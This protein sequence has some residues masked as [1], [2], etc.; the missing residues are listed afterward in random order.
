VTNK[1]ESRA[2]TLAWHGAKAHVLVSAQQWSL[3]SFLNLTGVKSSYNV[4][5]VSPVQQSESV[6]HR[7]ASPLCHHVTLSG[8]PVLCSRFSL[9]TCFFLVVYICESQSPDS[10]LL[11]FLPLVPIRLFFMSVSLFLLFTYIHLYHFSRFHIYALI[12][13][14]CFFLFLTYFAVYGSL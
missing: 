10:F 1:L 12:Y 2:L 9:V 11:P 5:L 3:F 7:C 13:D 4:V 14:I 6:I 8:V